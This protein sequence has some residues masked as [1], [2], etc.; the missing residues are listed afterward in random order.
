MTAARGLAHPH[1][2]GG[3]AESRRAIANLRISS[4]PSGN[5]RAR[6][7]QPAGENGYFSACLL[8]FPPAHLAPPCA[9]W[10][11]G[12][13]TGQRF[14]DKTPCGRTASTF[15]D[16]LRR[17][18]PPWR[19]RRASIYSLRSEQRQQRAVTWCAE[20]LSRPA[21]GVHLAKTARGFNGNSTRSMKSCNA[22]EGR[23]CSYWVL[24]AGRS[25]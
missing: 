11:W 13:R 10:L 18:L 3:A 24:F 21:D 25:W 16:A 2:G 8:S 9:R 15:S 14:A 1:S 23:Y 7:F 6:Q 4:K 20:Q 19:L 5:G 17:N 12:D 22:F